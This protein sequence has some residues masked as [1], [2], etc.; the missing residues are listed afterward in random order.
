MLSLN[1]NNT[2]GDRSTESTDV[3]MQ[4]ASNLL[5]RWSE[6]GRQRKRDSKRDRQTEDKGRETNNSFRIIYCRAG[7]TTPFAVGGTHSTTV[8]TPELMFGDEGAHKYVV[9][10]WDSNVVVM[11][12]E[13]NVTV[14]CG[15]QP[16][17]AFTHCIALHSIPRCHFILCCI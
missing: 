7:N 5:W 9:K 11:S 6:R 2:C 3:S 16:K 13:V 8:S 14:R 1:S 10:I 15:Y 12:M 17:F 4:P